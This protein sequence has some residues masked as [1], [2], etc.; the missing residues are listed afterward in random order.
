MSDYYPAGADNDDAPW[1]QE[2]DEDREARLDYYC[3]TEELGGDE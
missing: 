3:M 1:N 2:E